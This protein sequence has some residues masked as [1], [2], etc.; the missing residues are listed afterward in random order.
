MC[1]ASSKKKKKTIHTFTKREKN[2]ERGYA[3]KLDA[4]KIMT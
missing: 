1:E 4:T 3:G 2:R